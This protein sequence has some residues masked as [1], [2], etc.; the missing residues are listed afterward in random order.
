[1][2]KE[3]GKVS[4]FP[5][6]GFGFSYP[7][8]SMQSLANQAICL[9]LIGMLVSCSTL[10]DRVEKSRKIDKAKLEMSLPNVVKLGEPVVAT[11]TLKNESNR[12]VLW[13][14]VDGVREFYLALTKREG[15]KWE[16]V[17]SPWHKRGNKNVGEEPTFDDFDHHIYRR[18]EPGQ[19]EVWHLDINHLFDLSRGD[20]MASASMKLDRITKT[21]TVSVAG[22]QFQVK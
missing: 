18:L 15:S 2:G 13:E 4:F 3:V 10:S 12:P 20:Y 1:V 21:T 16:A 5:Y 11:L 8:I 9:I 19:S 7:R 6:K 17:P 22:I 14:E